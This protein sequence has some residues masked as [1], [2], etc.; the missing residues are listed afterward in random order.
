MS[1]LHS[2]ESRDGS[3]IGFETIGQG[4]PLVLVHGSTADRTRWTPVLDTLAE[5]FTV[6]AVDRRG[7]GL[8]TA[9]Q[10]PYDLRR[11]GEDIAAV[12][13]AV[14]PDVYLVAH[15]YG[16]LCSLEAAL[17]TNAIHR[18]F[19]YE[20]PTDGRSIVSSEARDKVRKVAATGD[21]EATLEALFREALG[22]P[23]SAIQAMKAS[24]T[25]QA[26]LG[27]APTVMREIDGV[28]SF[29]IVDRLEKITIPVRLLLGT[30]SPAYFRSTAEAIASRLPNADLATLDRQAHL[31]VDGDPAQ[32]T[33]AVFAF[34]HHP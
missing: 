14:G 29:D 22:T 16:A 10:T 25:W 7:R 5:R 13:E 17:L 31:G 34:D 9:E 27:T 30:E 26:R 19:L 24:P 4:P 23:P 20:P 15:S 11:E 1:T 12:V 21:A 6:H 32:F 28:E 8:S 2:V 3:V 33:A 18:M